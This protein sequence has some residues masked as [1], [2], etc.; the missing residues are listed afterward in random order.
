MQEKINILKMKLEEASLENQREEIIREKEK[1]EN[2]LE[3]SKEKQI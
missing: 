2:E 1:F 3:E